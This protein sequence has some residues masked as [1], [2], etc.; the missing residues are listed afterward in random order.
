MALPAL[1]V[2][3]PG[4]E[5]SRMTATEW[6]ASV[7]MFFFVFGP[8]YAFGSWMH[9]HD[10]PGCKGCKDYNLCLHRDTRGGNPDCRIS[11]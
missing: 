4:I 7:F 5:R 10:N 8:I 11:E 9:A 6:M 3:T 1:L 2:E